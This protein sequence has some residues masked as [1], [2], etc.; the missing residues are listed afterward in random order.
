MVNFQALRM[1]VRDLM[2]NFPEE[3]TGGEK[4]LKA[5]DRYKDRLAG[6]EE[7]LNRGDKAA[8]KQVDEILALQ[9]R[10]LLANP[11]LDIDRLLLIKRRPIGGARRAKGDK[12][13][14]KGLGK[15]LGLP[16]QSSWQLHT[17]PNTTGWDNEISI[18]SPV[19]TEGRLTT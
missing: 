13:N 14:D 15:F 6:L 9:R 5:I 7:A 4:Y 8:L 3:Y 17:M 18:L 2:K 19:R 16:Q 1:A 10:A 11:L 12:E